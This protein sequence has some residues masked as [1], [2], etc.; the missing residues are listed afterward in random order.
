MLS[1]IQ[2]VN[3]TRDTS[4]SPFFLVRDCPSLSYEQQTYDEVLT[5]LHKPYI[6]LRI[7]DGT[8]A[9]IFCNKY[10]GSPLISEDNK[11]DSHGQQDPEQRQ[12]AF[13]KA[14]LS[15][16]TRVNRDKNKE[17][18]N[19]TVIQGADGKTYQWSS[20]ITEDPQR[21][22]IL[23]VDL[24]GEDVTNVV[25]ATI[26]KSRGLDHDVGNLLYGVSL[27][28]E[29][30][31]AILG[32]EF[33]KGKEMTE[34]IRKI[35]QAAMG[36][37]RSGD[38]S[39]SVESIPL[40]MKDM[41]ALISQEL[42]IKLEE[43]SKEFSYQEK[44]WDVQGDKESVERVMRN[45]IDNALRYGGDQISVTTVQRSDGRVRIEVHDNGCGIP[46][47][48]LDSLFRDNNKRLKGT[49]GSGTGL[50]VVKE[51]VEEKMGGEV[52]VESAP[53]KGTTFFF[54]LDAADSDR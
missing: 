47:N 19:P 25:Q 42:A 26:N 39:Y 40:N 35:V 17:N 41:I 7:I 46:L 8:V 48:H 31:R 43:T 44:P 36:L 30:L 49:P 20:I 24:I 9:T 45:L 33:P 51:L 28:N 11:G 13:E 10:G 4:L 22:G 18:P 15:L 50:A 14:A 6:Q 38:S 5:A 21:E 1:E 27:A 23:V 2:L 54:I 34:N 32:N 16:F 12:L 37:L 53:G 3:R 52:G 29:T